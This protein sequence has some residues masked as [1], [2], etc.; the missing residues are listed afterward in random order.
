MHLQLKCHRIPWKGPNKQFR[1]ADGA[2]FYFS[3]S[4]PRHCH[5]MCTLWEHTALFEFNPHSHSL[6]SLTFLFAE[7]TFRNRWIS[8]VYMQ[9]VGITSEA[10]QSQ[11][12]HQSFREKEIHLC[13]SEWVSFIRCVICTF[14]AI[15]NFFY[16]G[17]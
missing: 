15:I 7:F 13:V 12:Y 2:K 6:R 4:L 5:L 11:Q 16:Y 10:Q 17:I 8:F 3:L 1:Q 9:Q 14:H